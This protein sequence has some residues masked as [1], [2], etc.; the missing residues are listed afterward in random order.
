MGSKFVSGLGL[1]IVILS[2]VAGCN[3]AVKEQVSL[4]P[5]R[6]FGPTETRD[7]EF[8]RVALASNAAEIR[9]AQLALIKSADPKLKEIAEGLLRDHET[10]LASLMEI[11]KDRKISLENTD[12]NQQSRIAV[13]AGSGFNFDKMWCAEMIGGHEM[14][15]QILESV[16]ETT[17]DDKIRDVVSASIPHLISHLEQLVDYQEKYGTSHPDAPVS[18]IAIN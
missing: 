17:D 1:F 14:N 16:W 15:F 2:L 6:N 7:T 18:Q 10:I 4:D 5:K 11:A 13:L 12:P 8:V 3:W 9:F